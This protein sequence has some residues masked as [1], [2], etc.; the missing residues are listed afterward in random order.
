MSNLA[1]VTERFSGH[2]QVP[3]PPHWGGYRIAPEVIEFWQG[4]ENRFTTEFVTGD[5]VSVCNPEP[6][7]GARTG[8]SLKPLQYNMFSLYLRIVAA[9][10][11]VSAGL[12]RASICGCAG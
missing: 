8:C 1:A 6:Q 3:V 10:G 4:R 11:L 5:R 2:A 9:N 7:P 12:T